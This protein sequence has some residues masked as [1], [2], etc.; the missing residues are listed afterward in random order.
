MLRSTQQTEPVGTALAD[1]FLDYDDDG[2]VVD[3]PSRSCESGRHPKIFRLGVSGVLLFYCHL[4]AAHESG[5][6]AVTRHPTRRKRKWWWLHVRVHLY[7]PLLPL[8]LDCFE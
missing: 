1:V 7:L 5:H 4:I 3:V 6:A 8:F 2:D